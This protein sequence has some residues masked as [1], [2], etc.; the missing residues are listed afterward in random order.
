MPDSEGNSHSSAL[1]INGYISGSDGIAETYSNETEEKSR[2]RKCH[3]EAETSS[4]WHFCVRMNFVLR[5]TNTA[6]AHGRNMK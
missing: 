5:R 2:M 4:A 1:S 3:A 6:G